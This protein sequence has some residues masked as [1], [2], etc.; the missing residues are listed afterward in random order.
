MREILEELNRLLHD[1]EPATL[2]T[3]TRTT[4]SAYRKEGAKMIC[5]DGGRLIGSISGGCLESDVYE[6]SLRVMES[7]RSEVV[8]YDTN[9]ENDN[10][11]GLGIGCNGTV[12]VSIESIEWWR[13]PPG[14]EVFRELARRVREGR[15]CS[16]AT[17]IATDGVAIPDVRRMFV[18]PGEPP[19]ASLGDAALDSAVVKLTETI[20]GK[21][22]MR[23]SRKS[24]VEA[25]GKK[26]DVFVDTLIPPMRLLVFGAGH[27]AIPLVRMA[28]EIGM[29]VTV[30]DSRPQFTTEDRFPDAD[31]LICV[32]AEHFAEKVPLAGRPALVLMSHHYLKDLAVLRQV[33]ESKEELEYVGALGPR[34]RTEKMLEDLRRDGVNVPPE[35]LEMIRAPIGL[36]LG[37]ESPAEI[38]LSV[39][40]EILAARNRRSAEPLRKKKTSIHEAA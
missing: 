9:A 40:A 15:I 8:V 32:D 31:R 28:R 29:L 10:V 16:L 14:R 39:L 25:D 13:T 3:V 36:D 38:A 24:L 37:S 1:S 23:A 2:V 17:L 34:A 33:L 6:R 21:A 5:R 12:E 19:V 26:H 35:Q 18:H 30:I 11:W 20:L 22:T 7:G 27:D 4:G